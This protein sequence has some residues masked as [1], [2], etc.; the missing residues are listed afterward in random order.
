MGSNNTTH[1]NQIILDLGKY[2]SPITVLP[3]QKRAMRHGMRNP[4][5]LK[6]KC[7]AAC[8]IELGEYSAALPGAKASDKIG[9]TGINFFYILLNG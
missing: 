9:E 2:S 6:V 3:K 8:M 4:H 7:Y 1:L 5:E